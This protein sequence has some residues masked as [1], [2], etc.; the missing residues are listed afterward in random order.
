MSPELIQQAKR[1]PKAFGALYDLLYPEVYK[2]IFFRVK[3]VELAED[4]TSIVWEK[5]LDHIREFRSNEPVAFKVWIFTIARNALYEQYR[6]QHQ[7]TYVT[8][9]EY[10]FVDRSATDEVVKTAENHD[11]LLKLVK[12]LP[13]V[14]RE[15]VSLKFFSDFKNKEIAGILKVSE[16][17]VAAYLTR[18]LS[19]LRKRA[20]GHL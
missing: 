7:H 11:L 2:Y 13:A 6:S 5:V 18:A 10:E 12:G 19:T 15:I 1:D 3:T 9:E 20:K 16:K 8:I 14:E 4:L 17:M